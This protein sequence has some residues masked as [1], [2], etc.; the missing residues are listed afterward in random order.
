MHTSFRLIRTVL[1]LLMIAGYITQP[2]SALELYTI[3]RGGCNAQ[4]G[5][6]INVDDTHVYQ[7]NIAG[8][9]QILPREGIEHILVY[10]PIGNPFDRLDPESGIAAHIREVRVL[11]R[12]GTAFIGWPIRFIDDL[13]VF[14]DLQGKTHLVRMEDIQRFSEPGPGMVVPRSIVEHHQITFG[15]GSNLPQ[16]TE[17]IPPGSSPVQP[18]RMLSDQIRIQKFL[19]VYHNG[20][21]RLK[22]LQKRTVFYAR[23]YTFDKKTKIALV[24]NRDDFQEEFSAGLP[25]YFQWPS[26]STFGPQGYLV[27][28]LKPIEHLPSVE[29]IFNLR[30][31]GKYHF[32]SASF[33][34]NPFAFSAG[35]HF[36]IENRFFME[37]FFKKKDPDDLLFLPQFNQV[38]FTG[39][40]WGPYSFSAGYYYP[41]FGLQANGIFRELLSESAA[42]ILK[43]QYTSAD[44]RL[45][46][47]ASGIVMGSNDPGNESINLIYA[48]E[49][50]L[51]SS[52]TERSRQLES[53]LSAFSLDAAFFRVNLDLDLARDVRIGLSEVVIQGDYRETISGSDYQLR[54]NHITTSAY[55]HQDFGD[56]V[57]LKGQL[58][59]FLRNYQA[60][61]EQQ[62]NRHDESKFSFSVAVEFIL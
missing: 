56:S 32:L 49:M 57:A 55:V 61:L 19:T 8:K 12:E 45:Q 58:N 51:K 2:L 5:L 7:I 60:R 17:K 43:A 41:L 27:V 35:S 1:A 3:I 13:I 25:V 33:S 24:I 6:I 23:P 21:S 47:I 39:I 46:L 54:F 50:A 14:F 34:G 28:G 48:D 18:T 31:D 29:P 44:Y 22:R 62:K 36:M 4:T 59:H 20:F 26:G 53:A 15:Y 40:E 16:C 11:S 52:R 42:T 9:L 37:S 30:F 38:A 10:N